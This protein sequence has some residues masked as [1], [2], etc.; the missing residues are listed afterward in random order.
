MKKEEI[1]PLQPYSNMSAIKDTVFSPLPWRTRTRHMCVIFL[2]FNAQ[3]INKLELVGAPLFF[4]S[5]YN[6]THFTEILKKDLHYWL[7]MISFFNLY[8]FSVF[9]SYLTLILKSCTLSRDFSVFQLCCLPTEAL[10]CAVT[11]SPALSVHCKLL[12]FFYHPFTYL[13]STC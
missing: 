5:S 8:N 10:C 3:N 2:S 11:P 4:L 1:C 7:I 12:I 9:P 6:C 13:G